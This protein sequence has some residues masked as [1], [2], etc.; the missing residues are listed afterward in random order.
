MS[1]WS[2]FWFGVLIVTLVAFIPLALV[3]MI[4]GGLDVRHL[5]R[6]LRS[7]RQDEFDR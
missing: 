4:G 2:T 3:V 6:A 1:G 7:A 5:F